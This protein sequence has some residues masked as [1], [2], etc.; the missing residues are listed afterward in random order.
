[1]PLPGY[2][3]TG[4]PSGRHPRNYI[5]EQLEKV[6]REEEIDDSFMENQTASATQ[7]RPDRVD[8][9]EAPGIQLTPG[10]IAAPSPAPVHG[11]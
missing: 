6:H 4:P 5:G 7:L 10:D 11:K 1:M 3:A 9:A 2:A 8:K